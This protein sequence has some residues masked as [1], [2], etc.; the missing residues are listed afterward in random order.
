M[1]DSAHLFVI[2]SKSIEDLEGIVWKRPS[3]ASYV[4]EV[5]FLLRKK[6][7]KDLTDEDIRVGLTQHVG[8]DYLVPLAVK[9]LKSN[10][11]LEARHYEGDLL[12]SLLDL[13]SEFWNSRP[14][15]QQEVA[16]IASGI[17]NWGELPNSLREAY[18]R[19][20]GNIPSRVWLR[21]NEGKAPPP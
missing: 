9:R 19:F 17:S 1:V 18:A 6:S 5:S 7:I 3:A 14:E 4:A 11:M 16:H 8:V 15:L 2:D 10:P 13:P 12:R 21:P 20:T